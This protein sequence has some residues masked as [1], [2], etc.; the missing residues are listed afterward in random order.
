MSTV[1]YRQMLD[2]SSLCIPVCAS[3]RKHLKVKYI[4]QCM[5][6]A[7]IIFAAQCYYYLLPTATPSFVRKR[8]IQTCQQ[9]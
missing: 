5:A 1:N 7:V 4:I 6:Q 9:L 2:F 3:L 8:A